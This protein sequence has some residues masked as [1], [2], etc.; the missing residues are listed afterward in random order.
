[1]M[2]TIVVMQLIYP[3]FTFDAKD[4]I[5]KSLFQLS[6]DDPKFYFK[7]LSLKNFKLQNAVPEPQQI[8]QTNEGPKTLLHDQEKTNEDK[9]HL[10]DAYGYIFKFLNKTFD[11]NDEPKLNDY[12]QTTTDSNTLWRNFMEKNRPNITTKL[13]IDTLPYLALPIPSTALPW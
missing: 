9:K 11:T 4:Q 6:P 13:N 7:F 5:L 1:M 10:K 2:S 8:D 3:I 12:G